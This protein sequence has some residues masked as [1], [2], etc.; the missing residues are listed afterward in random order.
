MATKKFTHQAKLARER[1][2]PRDKDMAQDNISV[3]APPKVKKAPFLMDA[4]GTIYPYSEA[5][6][7]RGDLLV[8][9][10][11]EDP[12][13]YSTDLAQIRIQRELEQAREQ[14]KASEQARLEAENRELEA[15]RQRE[16]AEEQAKASERA[17]Q[18]AE[19]KLRA[20]RELHAKEMAEMRAKLEAL[21]KQAGDVGTSS[22]EQGSTPPKKKAPPRK[23]KV[24]IQE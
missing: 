24:E 3:T 13:R 7:Q 1:L 21:T 20:E 8:P 19:D 16:E 11:P 14:G 23:K 10:D 6:A 22:V 15:Q 12:E 17:A 4:H 9:Y 18:E 2:N 5:F